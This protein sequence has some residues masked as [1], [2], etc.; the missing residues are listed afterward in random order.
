MKRESVTLFVGALVTAG[1]SLLVAAAAWLVVAWQLGRPYDMPF[2]VSIE[3]AW[4]TRGFVARV[5]LT[6][7]LV[8]IILWF[9]VRLWLSRRTTR[10]RGA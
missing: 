3:T 9:L 4:A 10:A 8:F 5:L 7:A 1:V 6:A 2:L